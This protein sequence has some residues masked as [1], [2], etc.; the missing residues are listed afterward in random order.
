MLCAGVMIAV[1]RAVLFLAVALSAAPAAASFVT[2]ETGQVRPLALSPDGSQLFAVNTPDDR[3]EIFSVA[4]DGLTHTG[5][6]PVGLE[7]CAVA[8]RTNGEVWVVNHL[9]DSVSIVDVSGAAPHVVRTLLVGDEP[10]DIV[11]ANG[12]AFITT[13]HR[14]QNSG[15]PFADLTTPG[16][17][18]ADV[19]VFNGTD[20]GMTL[21]GMPLAVINLFGDT[22][23]A[24]ATDGSTVYA[25]VFQSGN[26]TTSLSEGVVCNDPGGSP[27]NT[28]AG[29]CSVSGVSY[30]GGLPNPDTNIPLGGTK[31]PETGLVVKF[32]PA[33][34]HNHWEDGLGRNWDNGV[35][36]W[37][38][39]Y[40]VFRINATLSPPAPLPSPPGVKP[41]QPFA[42]V[43][44]ILFNMIFNPSTG[45]IYVTNGDAHNEVRFEGPGGGGSTVRG[46]LHEAHVTILDPV[47]GSVTPRRLNPHIVYSTVPSPPGTSAKSL[48]TPLGMAL[49][50]TAPTQ[51]LYVAAFG[52][53]K[54]GVLDV[55]QFETNPDYMPDTTAYITVPGGGPSGLVLDEPHGRLYIL[56]RFDNSIS[57]IDTSMHKEVAHLPIYNPEPTSVKIGRPFLYDAV[58]TSSNGEA[59]CASCHIFADFDSLAWDLGNPN[60]I[61]LRNCNHFRVGPFGSADFHPLKGPMTTQSLRGM[62]NA[63][64]MHWRGDRSG[65]NDPNNPSACINNGEFDEAADFKKFIVA[66]DG[67]LGRGAPIADTDMQKFTDFILQVT[68]PPNPNRLFKEDPTTHTTLTPDQQ[69]GSDFF[70]NVTSDTVQTCNG[71]HVTDPANGFFGTDGFSSFEN[72][73]QHVKIPHLRNLY[74]KVGMFGMPAIMFVNDLHDT[75]PGPSSSQPMQVRGFGFLHDGSIDTLFRFHSATVFNGGFGSQSDPDL[76]REQVDA[77]MLVFPSN[78][79]PIVGQEIT[80]GGSN[81]GDV[82]GRI[83]LLIQR[84]TAGECDL[85]VKGVLSNVQ[86]G[87]LL[88]KATGKFQ[89]D[90]TGDPE[91][92]DATLRGQTT[93]LGQEL[94]YTCVP[95]GSGV[96]IGIDRDEDGFPDRTE[97]EAGSDPADPNSVPAGGSTTTTTF[98]QPPSCTTMPV[99]DPRAIVKVVTRRGA[100][101]LRAKMVIDLAAYMNEDVLVS[102]SDADTP[103]IAGQ[104]VG[105]LPPQGSSGTKWRFTS[106]ADGVQQVSLRSL[107]SRQPGKSKLNVKAKRWFTA[108][109]ANQPA[110]S[111]QL[112][113]Q[114]GNLCFTHAGTRKVD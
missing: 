77:F 25:A 11:F 2:F 62:A 33:A 81:A 104:D 64:P 50:S 61:V 26:R 93:T 9:S 112:T 52:S 59:A 110:A 60:D 7:P 100:G 91:L 68:Y 56:T 98:P 45:K 82:G 83:D 24:L 34:G 85:V 28:V 97:I 84:A 14:G 13:A 76:V 51:T 101:Q 106:I 4:S 90:R 32:N 1:R 79:A 43:G 44:T 63:G 27:N 15:V 21:G 107:G 30:P 69:A 35:R 38:P 49:T 48:A 17:G 95:P 96:R 99:T 108:A 88:D 92:S 72:E 54:I 57:V 5:S 18:R 75:T 47:S 71:C 87:W 16:I 20:P 78:L 10:R 23:R 66:F 65:A 31:G 6:V 105:V 36:F 109:A 86:R 41:G 40:D 37:L 53:S 19:W 74:Q 58:A 3:L 73:T 113:V 67:L 42:G 111:T 22:P 89:S 114:I 55:G 12:R 29:A 94:T 46:H 80:L 39:D 102:L 103:L 70:F 8:A